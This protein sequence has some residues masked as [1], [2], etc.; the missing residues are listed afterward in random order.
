MKRVAISD[1]QAEMVLAE[2]VLGRNGDLLLPVGAQLT[3]RTIAVLKT[4][5]IAAVFVEG[6][7]EDPFKNYSQEQVAEA[8]GEILC[9]YTTAIDE[10]PVLTQLVKICTLRKLQ[11][12]FSGTEPTQLTEQPPA[13]S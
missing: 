10:D 5:E 4:R 3:D 8:E 11:K 12:K 6:E 1:L 9:R 13:Q 2:D 7:D